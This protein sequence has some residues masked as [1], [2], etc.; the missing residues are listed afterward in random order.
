[1]SDIT[2]DFI[3]ATN[4]I[5]AKVAAILTHVE[6]I[7][8]DVK[9]IREHSVEP[10]NKPATDSH[11]SDPDKQPNTPT[12]SGAG[13]VLNT[14]QAKGKKY[15]SG[16]KP[17]SSLRRLVKRWEKQIQ[18][19]AFQIEVA[20][21]IG[22]VFYTYQTCR[23][24]DLTQKN[25]E[26]TRNSIAARV[27]IGDWDFASPVRPDDKIIVHA[28]FTNI[29]HSPAA[30]G[31]ETMS[32]RGTSM[33]D[34]DIPLSLPQLNST[35]EPNIPLSQSIV[36]QQVA[37]EEFIYGIPHLNQLSSNLATHHLEPPLP[38]PTVFFVGRLVYESFGVQTERQFC[39]YMVYVDEPYSKGITK[40]KSDPRFIF[41]NCPKWNKTI[42]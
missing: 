12:S 23:T 16:D 22:L 18:K 35:M 31:L 42:N 37:S 8:G 9:S 19:P 2:T 30:Y 3:K 24:N 28:L 27:V 13:H 14:D 38:R 4:R 25:L 21:V 39:F 17:E 29:G 6:V 7:E 36:D 33:P 1:M 5:L 40:P 34:G 41:V 10:S 11:A 26:F 15:S 32:F 20:A